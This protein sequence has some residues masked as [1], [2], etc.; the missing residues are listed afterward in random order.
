MGRNINQCIQ[1]GVFDFE[2]NQPSFG[3]V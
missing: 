1:V 3:G 2:F